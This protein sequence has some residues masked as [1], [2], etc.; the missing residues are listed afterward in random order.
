MK[1]KGENKSNNEERP[2]GVDDWCAPRVILE[3]PFGTLLRKV[4]GNT[5]YDLSENP[6]T[7]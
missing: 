6:E 5:I 3:R 1:R 2:R 7:G 4:K